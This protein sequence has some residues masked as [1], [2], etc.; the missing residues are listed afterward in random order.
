MN[1]KQYFTI[2]YWQKILSM[3][4]SKTDMRGKKV[5]NKPIDILCQWCYYPNQII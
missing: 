5:L 3:P 4:L 2:N 1:F